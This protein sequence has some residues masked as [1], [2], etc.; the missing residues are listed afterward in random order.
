VHGWW[1]DAC[2]QLRVTPLIQ[3]S[4]PPD[5]HPYNTG[6]DA[7]AATGSTTPVVQ[8]S[9]YANYVLRFFHS[10][11]SM[12]LDVQ[13]GTARCRTPYSA[14]FGVKVPTRGA[15]CIAVR[16]RAA[17][18]MPCGA[19]GAVWRRMYCRVV[20]RGARCGV[21]EPL[22]NEDVFLICAK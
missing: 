22:G 21:K 5:L 17:C 6:N 2:C 4:I 20:P 13:Y 11:S 16:C 3:P 15:G 1:E 10:G 8:G 9:M 7:Q 12:T 18:A 14:G 19:C